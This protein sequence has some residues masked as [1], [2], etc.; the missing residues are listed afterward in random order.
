MDAGH[1]DAPGGRQM[2]AAGALFHNKSKPRWGKLSGP[3]A[4]T[5]LHLTMEK[6][7]MQKPAV[8]HIHANS[9]AVPRISQVQRT[10]LRQLLQYAQP[11]P[12]M[13]S[14]SSLM[15]ISCHGISCSCIPM[16]QVAFGAVYGSE[17]FYGLWPAAWRSYHVSVIELYPILAAVLIWGRQW[18]NHSVC[19]FVFT[20]IM[21]L[22]PIINKQTS[23]DPTIT[24]LLRPLV[25]ACLRCNINFIAQHIPG[26]F[27]TL[28]DKLSR[29]QVQAF[30][31]LAPWAEAKPR[32]IP[33]CVSA[34]GLGNL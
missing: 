15:T 5:A 21:R 1:A 32:E 6:C 20:R 11:H 14:A 7:V 33:Y 9:V 8:T 2:T 25:L 19:F 16:L 4:S 30:H 24:A 22:V 28:A 17:W 29:S 18:R 34:E 3:P 23:R 13:A 26:R 10:A 31:T 12:Q 27:N